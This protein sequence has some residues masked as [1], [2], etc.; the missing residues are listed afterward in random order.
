MEINV[1]KSSYSTGIL[2]LYILQYIHNHVTIHKNNA[3]FSTIKNAY[4][5]LERVIR[6]LTDKKQ[7]IRV[8]YA[9]VAIL[10][11]LIRQTMTV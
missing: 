1:G 3:I 10:H 2:L 8:I 7:C 6:Q 5:R 11:T 9:T 4:N